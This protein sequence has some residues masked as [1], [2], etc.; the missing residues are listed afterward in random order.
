MDTNARSGGPVR[1]PWGG[2][3]LLAVFLSLH[4]CMRNRR[5]G[6]ECTAMASRPVGRG[7]EVSERGFSGNELA[8]VQAV[9]GCIVCREL[10]KK[11]Q[12]D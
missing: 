9:K 8:Q 11:L 7:E 10:N 1:G 3:L 5:P 4:H 6:T 12:M 2:T